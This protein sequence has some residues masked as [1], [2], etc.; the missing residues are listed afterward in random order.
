MICFRSISSATV[1]VALC[2]TN[3]Y[4]ACFKQTY[5]LYD[6][7]LVLAHELFARHTEAKSENRENYGEWSYAVENLLVLEHVTETPSIDSYIAGINIYSSD[8]DTGNCSPTILVHSKQDDNE[9]NISV[10][11]KDLSV[12]S[13]PFPPFSHKSNLPFVTS[14]IL[15]INRLSTAAP[16][17]KKASVGSENAAAPPLPPR[18]PNATGPK[19]T[20]LSTVQTKPRNEPMFSD[21][22]MMGFPGVAPYRRTNEF[23]ITAEGFIPL[24]MAEQQAVPD[25]RHPEAPR[26]PGA[27]LVV[28]DFNEIVPYKGNSRWFC[29]DDHFYVKFAVSA[30]RLEAY[31]HGEP[32]ARR[33]RERLYIRTTVMTNNTRA[34]EQGVISIRE[35][36]VPSS[37]EQIVVRNVCITND[38]HIGSSAIWLMVWSDY[39]NNVKRK[40]A[41]I[42]RAAQTMGGGSALQ[43][44]LTDLENRVMRI[45]GVQFLI[46]IKNLSVI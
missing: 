11:N 7:T 26:P 10:P 13:S 45:I 9:N 39:K 4:Q 20:K 41:K 43:L 23:A 44:S 28:D 21:I 35:F 6:A 42:N 29:R 12:Q 15:L 16:F 33:N 5:N 25:P 2:S 24:L 34:L 31:R 8:D 46:E 17:Y 30:S 36:L 27:P 40:W 18:D 14:F 32:L 37:N 3:S 19:P 1:T 22:D 38:K